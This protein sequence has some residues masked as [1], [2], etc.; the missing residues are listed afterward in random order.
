MSTTTP[1]YSSTQ[2]ESLLFGVVMATADVLEEKLLLT[3]MVQSPMLVVVAF[4]QKMQPKWTDQVH[5]MPDMLPKIWLQTSF[6]KNVRFLLPM[7]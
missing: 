1:R 7:P 4:H 6:A 5:T 2:V 3:A